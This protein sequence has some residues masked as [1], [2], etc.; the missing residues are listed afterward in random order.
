MIDDLRRRGGKYDDALNG[1][2]FA[3]FSL[4]GTED[5]EDYA[6]LSIRGMLLESAT[7][8]EERLE[9]IEGLLRDIRDSLSDQSGE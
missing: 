1:R 4:I 8:I 5:W 2:R 7:D 3:S 9:R 6:S